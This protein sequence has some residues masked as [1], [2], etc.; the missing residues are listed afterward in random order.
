MKFIILQRLYNLNFFILALYKFTQVIFYRDLDLFFCRL[1]FKAINFIVLDIKSLFIY[2]TRL[3][4][5][6]LHLFKHILI[7]IFSIFH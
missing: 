6:F 5:S 1:I 4:I 2:C 3:N 7:D